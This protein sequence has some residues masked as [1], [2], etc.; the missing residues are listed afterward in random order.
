[1]FVNI[2]WCAI[3]EDTLDQNLEQIKY[4]IEIDGEEINYD[5]TVGYS[6]EYEKGE[7]PGFDGTMVCYGNGLMTYDW[8][9]GNHNVIETLTSM[10]KVSVNLF[11]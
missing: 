2:G 11:L 1:V 7:F 3:D 9:K 4:A 6:Q 10:E 5:Y 8:P